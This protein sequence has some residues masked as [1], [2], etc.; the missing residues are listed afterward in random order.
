MVF[1]KPAACG[2]ADPAGWDS[3]CKG[4]RRSVLHPRWFLRNDGP[5][6]FRTDAYGHRAA[7]GLLQIVSR[8]IRV[9]QRR[10]RDGVENAFIAEQPSDGGIY[11]AGRGFRPARGFEFPGYCV[12]RTN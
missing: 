9:D 5:S 6:R 2:P 11:R 1:N 7:A 3:R 4:D 12:L 8:R 10:E